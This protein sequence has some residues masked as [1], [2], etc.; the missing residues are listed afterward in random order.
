MR[1]EAAGTFPDLKASERQDQHHI[2]LDF[3]LRRAMRPRDESA[4]RVFE[5]RFRTQQVMPHAARAAGVRRRKHGES[6]TIHTASQTVFVRIEIA[7][8]L[9]AENRVRRAGPFLGG[10]SGHSSTSTGSAG[11]R[12]LAAGAPAR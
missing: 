5:H 10:A 12:A 7:R 1:F 4:E 2:A 3:R 9:A 6:I 11:R 8:L